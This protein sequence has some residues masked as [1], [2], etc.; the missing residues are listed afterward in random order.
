[1]QINVTRKPAGSL[2]YMSLPW[3]LPADLNTFASQITNL[4]CNISTEQTFFLY[5]LNIMAR[6]ITQ[7]VII[8][9]SISVIR[10]SLHTSVATG[11]GGV[12]YGQ[13][14]KA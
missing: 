5:I 8:L 7:P 14:S 2:P 12:V 4:R 3:C 6:C 11:L 10:A 13:T 1:M 9:F